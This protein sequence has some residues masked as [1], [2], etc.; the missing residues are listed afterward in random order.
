MNWLL[1]S[2]E[3]VDA[4]TPGALV[5]Y[6]NGGNWSHVGTITNSGRVISKWGLYPVYEHGLWEVPAVYGNEIRYFLKPSPE[7]ALDL[8]EE[9]V[10]EQLAERSK[11]DG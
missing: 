2:L 7:M 4:Q 6:F 1:S 5:L 8:F 9:Y 10:E 3:E 11:H